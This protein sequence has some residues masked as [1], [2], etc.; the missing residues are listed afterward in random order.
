MH[1]GMMLIFSKAQVFVPWLHIIQLIIREQFLI[2]SRWLLNDYIK[3][4]G[5]EW[6]ARVSLR[7]DKSAK[8]FCL[9]ECIVHIK[10]AGIKTIKLLRIYLKD[11]A[12]FPIIV[13]TLG[14]DGEE[15]KWNEILNS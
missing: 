10:T 5:L 8:E 11:C 1:Y 2:S 7:F 4:W 3:Q 9:G 14:E 13:L 12:S 6:L 15:S